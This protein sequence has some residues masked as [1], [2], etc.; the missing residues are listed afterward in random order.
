MR[1]LLSYGEVARFKKMIQSFDQITTLTYVLIDIDNFCPCLYY[2]LKLES[3]KH[4]SRFSKTLG[5][6]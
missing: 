2:S 6:G 5:L 4:K 3:Q 1:P